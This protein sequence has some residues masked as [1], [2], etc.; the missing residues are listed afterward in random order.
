MPF[1][2]RL[3]PPL[4]HLIQSYNRK[5]SEIIETYPYGAHH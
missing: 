5:L 4:V 3:Y 1:F 2:L